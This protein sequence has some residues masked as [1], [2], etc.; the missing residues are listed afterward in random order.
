MKKAKRNYKIWTLTTLVPIFSIS[1]GCSEVQKLPDI[2]PVSKVIKAGN[3]TKKIE[4]D[5]KKLDKIEKIEIKTVKE[6][7][8][9]E[10]KKVVPIKK[11]EKVEKIEI[12]T[13]KKQEKLETNTKKQPEI[14]SP[15]VEI[16]KTIKKTE[17]PGQNQKN[18][19]LKPDQKQPEKQQEIKK[20]EVE[21]TRKKEET[22]KKNEPVKSLDKNEILLTELKAHLGNLPDQI[23]VANARKNDNPMT[24]V[25]KATNEY[26]NLSYYNIVN[27]IGEDN[28]KYELKLDFFNA[29]Y[30]KNG[31]NKDPIENVKLILSLKSNPNIKFSKVVTVFYQKQ[32]KTEKN[33]IL[34]TKFPEEFKNIY[35][36]FIAF[37]I[38]NREKENVVSLP[39]FNE[40]GVILKN[41]K[42]GF[43]LQN[44]LVEFKS[45]NPENDKDKYTFEVLSAKADDENGK[46]SLNLRL[47]KIKDRNERKETFAEIE[48]VEI[49]GFAKNSSKNYEFK[50]AEKD[51]EINLLK[52]NLK[53]KLTVEKLKSNFTKHAFLKILFEKMHVWSSI[54]NE[55]KLI[56]ISDLKIGNW[57][58]YPQLMFL[59]LNPIKSIDNLILTKNGNK[60]TWKL[61]LETYLLDKNQTLTPQSQ[62]FLL[63]Q[64][65]IQEIQGSLNLD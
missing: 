18:V 11:P 46:L 40:D 21:I 52:D 16:K 55:K 2:N 10:T 3:E 48:T 41:R 31:Q 38:L 53:N 43:G 30:N 34:K 63:G 7:E 42:F 6:Q 36:S 56:K 54:E 35:P 37:L 33:Y 61:N 60:I 5:Q 15:K 8:K 19:D 24:L 14:T 51:F 20:A 4:D 1:H 29:K 9:S 25:Y 62:D 22:L 17:N 44:E 57:I 50:L 49:S 13:I 39:F 47:W 64:K 27:P 58:V 28:E 45:K 32:E 59:D 23:Q 26:K 65:Q 12:K